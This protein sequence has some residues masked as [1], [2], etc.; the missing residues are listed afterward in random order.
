MHLRAICG[1]TRQCET[2]MLP[3]FVCHASA[4]SCV[5]PSSRQGPP[6]RSRPFAAS[7]TERRTRNAV[8]Q[9]RFLYTNR[10]T[11]LSMVETDKFELYVSNSV[12]RFPRGTRSIY[13]GL[14]PFPPAA[15]PEAHIEQPAQRFV[16]RAR[17]YAGT[18]PCHRQATTDQETCPRSSCRASPSR[19]TLEAPS[20]PGGVFPPRS[21]TAPPRLNVVKPSAR[22]QRPASP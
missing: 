15:P 22:E 17:G 6:A 16:P 8:G 20:R 11:R 9:V 14:P 19:P 12:E 1:A 2:I 3:K 21:S 4:R 7:R 10:L 13:P 18:D 5:P